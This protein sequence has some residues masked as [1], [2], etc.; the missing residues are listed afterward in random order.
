MGTH[1][2]LMLAAPAITPP[3]DPAF[4][5]VALFNQA[6][7]DAS[8][9]AGDVERVVI[10]VERDDGRISRYETMVSPH[11][12]ASLTCRYLERTVKFLLWSRGGFRIHFGGPADAGNAIRQIYTGTGARAFDTALME[13]V[14]EHPFE[15]RVMKADQVPPAKEAS[16]SPGG[17]LDGCRIGFDLGASDFKLAA[18][19]DGEVL[20]STELPWNPKDQADPDYHY[21][22]LADGLKLAA[23]YLPRVD[24]IGGSTAGVVVSNRLMVASLFRSV[25]AS[26]YEEARSLF[27]RLQREWGIPLEV[28]NDGIVSALAGAMSLRANGILGMA[29]GSSEATGYIAPDGGIP[30]WIDELAFAPVDVSPAAPAD[31]WSGDQGVGAM[32]FSQQAVNRL[33]PAAGMVFA[34][35]MPLPERLKAVQ[36]RMEKGDEAAAAI[37]RTI[38]IYLGYTVPH[39]ADFYDIRQVLMLGRVL[40]GDGGQIIV[41]EAGRVLRE[42]F[43]ETAGRVQ[44]SL[45]DEKSRR[46]GQAVAAASLP[47]I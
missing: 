43:P 42:L 35:D 45:P 47:R 44:I 3:L 6:Y 11:L 27:L 37:Y 7:R 32:Y 28:A 19:R 4:R 22:H 36:A 34:A 15:V 30:G 13:K 24:A 31:E 12:D 41:S 26:R 5:P 29:M 38:G 33:A 39:Y 23:G 20:F 9:A 17:H 21:R 10:G 25:P 2:D 18:V 16:S 8:Q 40:S 14:Y 46:V 1:D